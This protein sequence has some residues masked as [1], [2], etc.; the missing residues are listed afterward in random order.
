[1]PEYIN[2][3]FEVPAAFSLQGA[4]DAVVAAKGSS[5]AAWR[6]V[7]LPAAL[8]VAGQ[9]EAWK[10]TLPAGTK[11]NGFRPFAKLLAENYHGTIMDADYNLVRRCHV[12]ATASDKVLK[13][14]LESTSSYSLYGAATF[15]DAAGKPTTPPVRK[16]FAQTVVKSAEGKSKAEIRA[17]IKALEALLAK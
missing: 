5:D 1:M 16:T 17:A 7:L 14:Y 13:A 15:I 6:E 2:V 4:A 12:I 10:A 9:F 11:A 8:A 3:K